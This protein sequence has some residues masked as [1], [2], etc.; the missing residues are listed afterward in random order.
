MAEQFEGLTGRKLRKA[1]FKVKLEKYIDQYPAILICTIDHVGSNQMQKVRISIRGKGNILCGKNTMIR[2][3]MTDLVEANKFPQLDSLLQSD[4][5]K[6]N[7]ALIF[8]GVND[9]A[10]I[11]KIVESNQVPAAAKTGVVAPVDVTLPAGPTGL[12]PGQT[13]FFQAANIATKITKGSIELINPVTLIKKNEKVPATAVALLTKMGI[14]PFHF[15]IHVTSVYENGFIYKANVLDLTKEDLLR[16]F[17]SGVSYVA[18]VSLGARYPTLASVVHS[19]ARGYQK[20]AAIALETS[21]TFD[22]TK[23]TKALLADPEALKKAQEA[24]AAGAAAAAAPAAAVA[25]AVAKPAPEPEEEV[26]EAPVMDLFG[27]GGDY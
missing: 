17:V 12:D 16:K 6:F 26:D 5:I 14:R 20:L 21:Y 3:V 27:G 10:E 9:L 7:V 13:A 15:G 23:E 4:L 25:V 1:K 8:T 24:A 22:E 2:R 18:C 19:V 11:R